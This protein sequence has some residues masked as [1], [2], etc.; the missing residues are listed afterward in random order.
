MNRTKISGAFSAFV[1][2]AT[3][4]GPADAADDAADDSVDFTQ[5]VEVIPAFDTDLPVGQLK[6]SVTPD[7]RN[8][9]GLK[10]PAFICSISAS[11]PQQYRTFYVRGSGLQ[12]CA[13]SGWQPQNVKVTI[14]KYKTLG[15]WNNIASDTTGWVNIKFASKTVSKNCKSLGVQTYRIVVDAYVTYGRQKKSAQSADYVRFKCS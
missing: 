12:S 14:Q 8:T 7:S 5:D 3:L 4:V 10:S 2:A 6:Y 13:G 11:N 1:L 9:T 15:I